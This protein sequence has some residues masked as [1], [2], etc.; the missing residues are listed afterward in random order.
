[1]FRR[2][3]KPPRELFILAGVVAIRPE[4]A[5]PDSLEVA[6]HQIEKAARHAVQAADQ[7]LIDA[8]V[9]PTDGGTAVISDTRFSGDRDGALIAFERWKDAVVQVPAVSRFLRTWLRGR[10]VNLEWIDDDY[11]A[12]LAVRLD[13][14]PEQA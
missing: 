4:P 3:D 8:T 2:R 6:M 9:T 11:Q 13:A 14:D 12:Q 5:R 1:M 7:Q 10:D